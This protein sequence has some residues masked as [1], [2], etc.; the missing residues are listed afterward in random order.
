[1]PVDDF[2][3]RACES[4]EKNSSQAVMAMALNHRAVVNGCAH[5][6]IPRTFGDKWARFFQRSRH[7]LSEKYGD[8]L[9]SLCVVADRLFLSGRDAGAAFM[10]GLYESSG[11]EESAEWERLG[12]PDGYADDFGWANTLDSELARL[13]LPDEVLEG[14]AFDEFP[15]QSDILEAMAIVWFFDAALVFPED[16]GRA[17]DVLF[18]A[19]HAVDLAHRTLAWNSSD[20]C[21]AHDRQMANSAMAKTLN[22]ARH[23]KTNEAKAMAIEEWQKDPSRFASAEK[24]GNQIADWLETQGF[25]Y[26]PRT[27]TNWIRGHARQIGV[28]FR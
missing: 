28:R 2:D 24:A 17:F 18:E 5:G 6:D 3:L 21:H 12:T 10:S 25:K 19:A 14:T 1:M 26:E 11:T 15:D 20:E 23:R 4:S 9:E 8:R 7:K 22:S 16:P 27:V 13:D